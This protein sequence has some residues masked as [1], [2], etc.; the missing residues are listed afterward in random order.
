MQSD[1]GLI[2]VYCLSQL[3]DT[4]AHTH[5][6][7][8]SFDRFL[9]STVEEISTQFPGKVST[10]C[11]SLSWVLP[12]LRNVGYALNVPNRSQWV[13]HTSVCMYCRRGRKAFFGYP[14][15]S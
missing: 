2:A 14:V 3:T 5:T 6:S 10:F 9:H 8:T 15:H 4:R 1:L 7:C 13:V 12:T 11:T